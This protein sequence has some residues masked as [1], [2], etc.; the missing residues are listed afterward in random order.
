M[1]LITWNRVNRA[2]AKAAMPLVM[3][4]RD[5]QGLGWDGD[6]VVGWHKIVFQA[7]IGLLKLPGQ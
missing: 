5:V 4:G 6:M 7:Q 2:N 1:H 3:M